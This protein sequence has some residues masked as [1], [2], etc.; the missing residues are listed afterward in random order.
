[1][2]TRDPQKDRIILQRENTT[3]FRQ[4][5]KVRVGDLDLEQE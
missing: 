4:I 2:K 3:S 1:M 5:V